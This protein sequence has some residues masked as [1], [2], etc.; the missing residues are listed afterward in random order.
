LPPILLVTHGHTCPSLPKNCRPTSPGSLAFD[1]I[2]DAAR[3]PIAT[4]ANEGVVDERLKAVS[5][6]MHQWLFAADDSKAQP[7]KATKAAVKPTVAE[8]QS[9]T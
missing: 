1:S 2:G 5:D 8:S 7:K 6:F 3:N 9:R 4:R